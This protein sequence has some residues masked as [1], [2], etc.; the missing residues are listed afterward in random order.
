LWSECRSDAMKAQW[1][2][3]APPEILPQKPGQ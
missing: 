1:I 3:V 2:E